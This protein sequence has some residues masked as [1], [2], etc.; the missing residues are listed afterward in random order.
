[1]RAVFSSLLSLLVLAALL[2]G[3]CFSCPQLLLSLTAHTPA[4]SC[5]KHPGKQ[6]GPREGCHSVALAHFV[7]A[8][9]A[10]HAQ[11]QINQPAQITPVLPVLQLAVASPDPVA[12]LWHSPPDLQLLNSTFL[13]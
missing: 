9:P 6:S 13:I 3:N 2:W 10:P 4:H 12:K 1:M 5:C 11:L 7:K 8:D